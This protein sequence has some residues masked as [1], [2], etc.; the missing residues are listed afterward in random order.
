[1]E[2]KEPL[3]QHIKLIHNFGEAV[4]SYL[5]LLC[6]I[7]RYVDS[8]Q[9]VTCFLLELLIISDSNEDVYSQ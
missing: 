9:L 7:I 4:F 6:I 5:L 2:H 8:L 3:L 1:M